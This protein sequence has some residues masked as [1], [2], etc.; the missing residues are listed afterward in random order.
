MNHEEFSRRGIRLYEKPAQH[1]F[2]HDA[3][4]RVIVR[5]DA[6]QNAKILA[7]MALKFNCGNVVGLDQ[8]L[9]QNVNTGKSLL[10]NAGCKLLLAVQIVDSNAEL[11]A[12]AVVMNYKEDVLETRHLQAIHASGTVIPAKTLFL[13][14]IC[15][16]PKVGGGTY[17]LLRLMSKLATQNAAILCN[18]TNEKARTLFFKFGFHVITNRNDLYMLTRSQASGYMETYVSMLPSF[19]VTQQMCTRSGIR[20]PRKLYW[21]CSIP[22]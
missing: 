6:E 2:T 15:S 12:F 21:D 8:T 9:R 7:E 16:K 14:L 20:D 22:R 5:P 13:E 19:E 3:R 17:I 18:P 4:G 10:R 11:V 1:L